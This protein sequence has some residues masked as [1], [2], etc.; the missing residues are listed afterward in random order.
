MGKKKQRRRLAQERRDTASAW[1]EN[2]PPVPDWQVLD[3]QTFFE[4]DLP[5]DYEQ[6]ENPCLLELSKLDLELTD[7]QKEMLKPPEE[8]IKA[9]Q[10]P[11]ALENRVKQNRAKA[12]KNRWG[13]KFHGR[14]LGKLQAKWHTKLQTQ[15]GKDELLETSKGVAKAKL[16]HRKPKEPKTMAEKLKQRLKAGSNTRAQAKKLEKKG[17]E[18]CEASPWHGTHIRVTHEGLH[19]GR[20]GPVRAVFHEAVGEHYQLEVQAVGDEYSVPVVFKVSSSEARGHQSR[21]RLAVVILSY[22]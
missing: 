5:K 12:R 16:S 22:L 10:F 14:F 2:V 6:D 4:D 19:E 15:G 3:G 13:A 9:L 11:H 7:E 1:P 18:E 20:Y 17:L 8:R 21:T